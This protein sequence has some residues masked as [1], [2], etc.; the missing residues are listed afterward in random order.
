MTKQICE[1]TIRISIRFYKP[2]RYKPVSSFSLV[3]TPCFFGG[4]R[5]WFLC[6]SCS[7]RVGVLYFIQNA[8]ACR[9]CSNL[10]YRSQ[11]KNHVGSKA[12]YWKYW[13]TED[14][15]GRDF[16]TMRSR[17]FKGEPTKRYRKWLK[18]RVKHAM[19]YDDFIRA[20]W[21]MRGLTKFVAHIK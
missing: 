13:R 15:L 14:G 5:L 20:E 12:V 3:A 16:M 17:Y 9:S 10:A 11:Q 7:K 2:K 8:Y 21:K 18:R 19:S 4:E 6:P 1:K